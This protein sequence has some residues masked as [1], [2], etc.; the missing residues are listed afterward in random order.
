M[1]DTE[2]KIDE[3]KG[4]DVLKRMLRTPPEPK[5]K[6]GDKSRRPRSDKEVDPKSQSPKA[7]R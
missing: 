4:D 2:K 3:K 6:G 7:G 1:S 5:E